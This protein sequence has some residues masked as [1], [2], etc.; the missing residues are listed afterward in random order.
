M[1]DAIVVGVGGMG[2]A[3]AYHLAARG[4]SVLALERFQI[5][6]DRG[7]SHGFSRIIRL[8]YWEHPAYV[9]LVRRAYALWRDLETISGQS[10]LT[11]T[12]SI[13]AGPPDGAHARGAQAAC[14]R[15]DL[16]FD[17]LDGAHL[18]ERF[19]GYCLPA[20][21]AAIYQPD[22]GVLDPEACV[23]AHAACAVRHGADVRENEEVVGWDAGDASVTV[24]TRSGTYRGRR[25]ALAAGAWTGA[26]LPA[27]AATLVPERQAVLWT[28]PLR[29]ERFAVG[30]FP[31]FYIDV[32]GGPF[33]GFPAHAGRGFKIGRYHHRG[34]AVPDPDRVDRAFH[35]EDEAVLRAGIRRYF[36]DAD[37]PS[38]ATS[39]C[40]FTN[41]PDQHF[42][43]DRLP[44]S[45][46]VV[47]AG[48]SGH[49]FKFCSA[50]GEVVAALALDGGTAVDIGLFALSRFPIAFP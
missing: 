12:G 27:A 4:A 17:R 31:V 47:A 22:G 42:L 34:E 23:R 14:E 19:P 39:I 3:A 40:L 18:R 26:L 5:A 11:V 20:E 33:Y 36:P 16:A 15:F 10:L 9:P 38:E 46:V 48:F 28:R 32:P 8:A 24:R 45:P 41:T 43:I 13:D 25:L 37:G 49:G 7:S 35:P 50:V 21:V 29:P 2:S 6:H 44:A 1:Y 30:A